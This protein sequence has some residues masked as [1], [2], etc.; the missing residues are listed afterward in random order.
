MSDDFDA[1]S[2]AARALGEHVT[3]EPAPDAGADPG[4]DPG[5]DPDPDPD[6][7]ADDGADDAD[8]DGG[9][10]GSSFGPKAAVLALLTAPERGPTDRTWREYGVGE[11]MALVLDGATDWLL[12]LVDVDVGD[13]L[14]PLGKIGLGVSRLGD[15]GDDGDDDGATS[16]TSGS[17]SDGDDGD[18]SIDGVGGV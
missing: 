11:S 1:S 10:G 12:D 15:D 9:S 3:G 17:G 5:D 13:S 18:L 7:D 14:G 2:A 6:A 16:S 4:G 8:D